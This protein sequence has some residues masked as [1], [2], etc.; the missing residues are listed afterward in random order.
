MTLTLAI[1]AGLALLYGG[2]EMLV[3]GSSSL[4]RRLGLSPFVVSLTVVAFGTSAPEL[5]AALAAI[6]RGSEDLVMG[7]VL[8][9]NVANLGLILGLSVLLRPVAV[10]PSAFRRDLPLLVLTSLILLA[11][12]ARGRITPLTGLLLLI[13]LIGYTVLTLRNAQPVPADDGPRPSLLSSLAA[14]TGAVAVLAF[15]ADL[16]VENAVTLARLWGVGEHLIGLTVIALGT[17]LPELSSCLVAASRGDGD[18]IFGNLLGSNIFNVLAI[19]GLSAQAGPFRT[20][21]QLFGAEG[22]ILVALSL[23]LVLFSATGLRIARREGV[24]LL[25]CYGGYLAYLAA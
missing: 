1:V 23:L 18:F 9:S 21:W 24:C 2:G 11:F 4:A 19:L 8:G 5:A 14:V 16:L 20:P 15:G 12:L 10:A 22:L 3:R 7:N 6:L 17:S 13:L 25:A